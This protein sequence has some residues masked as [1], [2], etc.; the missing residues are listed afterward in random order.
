MPRQQVLCSLVLRP[1]FPPHF[2]VM[3]SALAVAE[4]VETVTGVRPDIK[5]PNDVLAA[6]RKL[7]GILIETGSTAANGLYA[8][9]GIGIN[10]NGSLAD[11]PELAQ[12]AT[13]LEQLAGHALQREA[14]AARLLAGLAERYA[15]LQRGGE[16][17]RA[18]VRAAWRARLVTLGAQ[19]RLAQSGQV[20]E[21]VAEDV[22]GD[23][24]LLLRRADGQLLTVTWGDVS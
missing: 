6:G 22:D 3:A 17:A 7:C 23:G 20:E 4:A 8:V 5:W 9:L 13:T 19:V 24:A 18:R 11:T 10:V 2:L 1:D 21:G 16:A 15:E 14:V 12:R